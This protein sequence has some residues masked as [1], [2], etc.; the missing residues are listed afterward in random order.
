MRSRAFEVVVKDEVAHAYFGFAPNIFRKEGI[1]GFI[2]NWANETDPDERNEI[3]YAQYQQMAYDSD[4]SLWTASESHIEFVPTKTC[5]TTD[6]DLG[7]SIEHYFSG[8]NIDDESDDV[9]LL[10]YSVTGDGPL[11]HDLFP[12]SEIL[13]RPSPR[14][15]TVDEF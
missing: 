9:T 2:C 14:T 8:E 10:N 13:H 3:P 6:T 15:P 7:Y 5:S 12:L 4:L 11:T 1:S